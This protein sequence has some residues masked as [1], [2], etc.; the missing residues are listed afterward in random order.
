M[1]NLA[2]LGW[3][4]ALAA[5]FEPHAAKGLAP[6]RVSLEHNHV[7][8]VLTATGEWLAESSGRIKYLA[9]GRNELPAVGDWVA[10]RP[11]TQGARA[12]IK[13]ILPRR[14]WFSRKAAGRGTTEQVVAA[15][16]D[17]VLVVFGLDI[18]VKPRAIERYL[19]LARQG[20]VRP[21]IVM[22]KSDLAAESAQAIEAAQSVSGGSPVHAV[23][24]RTGA[25]VDQLRQYLASGQ[26][27]AFL[28]PSGAGKS[29]LVN[30]LVGRELLPTGEVR[31]WD[32]RGR[33][34]SVHRELVLVETGGVIID[35]P[36]MRE[37][38]LWEP[39]EDSAVDETFADLVELGAECRFRDC[40][41]DREPGCAVK[42][43]VED[44][45]V[46]AGRYAS[47][48]KLQQERRD[49]DARRDERA[50]LDAKRRGR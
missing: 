43:A 4:S 49:L 24:A 17:T 33:H 40:Q 23:S 29:S 46:D 32:A 5:A 39:S 26:T 31:P 36:G 22:N 42:A 28:G 45:R 21:V 14:S 34:T 7:Y 2:L 25:G 3:T 8:R 20:A 18:W 13:A 11:D 16:V 44:G 37:L 6:G 50:Q 41:H 38:Q 1:S 9:S 30:N 12:Q 48:L 35:T 10:M 15:N 19:V 27:L 47:Y